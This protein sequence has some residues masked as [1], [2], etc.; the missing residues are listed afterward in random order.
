MRACECVRAC[1]C[2]CVRVCVQA[3]LPVSMLPFHH[4]ITSI[5]LPCCQVQMQW[6]DWE[7]YGLSESDV[8]RIYGAASYNQFEL[9]LLLL[10]WVLPPPLLLLLW[11]LLPNCPHH[12]CTCAFRFSL[13]TC[14]WLC[15][16]V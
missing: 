12:T 9:P 5:G 16:G 13:H 3:R 2:V 7:D 15:R 14:M 8:S 1:V 6:I 10:L 11:L 4:V